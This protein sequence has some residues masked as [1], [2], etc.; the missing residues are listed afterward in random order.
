MKECRAAGIY[1]DACRG[2]GFCLFADEYLVGR[3]LSVNSQT[4]KQSNCPPDD[5]AKVSADETRREQELEQIIKDMEE[6][7]E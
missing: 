1:G 6:S 5:I 4:M 3:D 2:V 7:D